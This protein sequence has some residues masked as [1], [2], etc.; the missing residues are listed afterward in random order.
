MNRLA[1]LKNI[2]DEA[3][4]LNRKIPFKSRYEQAVQNEQ[5]RNILEW[6]TPQITD[7]TDTLGS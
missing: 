2:L 6:E 5:V 3:D 1:E 4:M 7:L